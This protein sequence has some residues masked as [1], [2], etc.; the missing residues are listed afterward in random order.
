MQSTTAI[1]ATPAAVKAHRLAFVAPPKHT[2]KVGKC[3]AHAVLF[4]SC[5]PK[6][7]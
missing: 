5:C 4:T 3:T 7:K 2:P 1:T 6:C